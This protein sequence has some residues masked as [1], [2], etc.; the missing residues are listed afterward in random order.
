MAR[1]E[2]LEEYAR[3][4]WLSKAETSPLAGQDLQ[5]LRVSFAASW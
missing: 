5:D 3:L 4:A 2:E 1:L